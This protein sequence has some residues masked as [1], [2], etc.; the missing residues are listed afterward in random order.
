LATATAKALQ[1]VDLRKRWV[2]QG[3]VIWGGK[4]TDLADRMRR[5]HTL[6]AEV[7]KGMSFE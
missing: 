2:D 3:Y 1:D 6:W 5:E 4:G 7:T